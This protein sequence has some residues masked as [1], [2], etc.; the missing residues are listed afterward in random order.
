MRNL[1]RRGACLGAL[2]GAFLLAAG[3]ALAQYPVKPIRLVVPFP[4]ATASDTVGRLL[5]SS[6]A[7]SLGQAV[8]VENKPGADSAIGAAAVASA[9][10]DGYTLLLATN[11]FAALPALRKTL[12]FDPAKD[13]TPISFVSRFALFLYANVELPANSLADLLEYA[14]QHPAKLN[15]ATGNPTGIVAMAQM[16]SMAGNLKMTHVPYKGEPAGMIDLVANRVQ[17]MLATP[18]S[19][20]AFVKDGRLKAF[21]TTLPQRTPLAPSVPSLVERF[22][23]FSVVAWAALMAPAGLPSELTE[24]LSK[25]VNAAIERPD[26]KEQFARRQYFGHGSTP[27][28]LRLYLREQLELYSRALREAG[29]EPQ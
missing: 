27:D 3:P 8:V 12:P 23:K 5:A 13:F 19:A 18:G 26:L 1:I 7:A 25:E 11:G 14:R 20:E 17:L 6:L 4:A 16:L 10:P 28:E 9:A 2:L 24:R 15:Y 21:A 22:P 29:V